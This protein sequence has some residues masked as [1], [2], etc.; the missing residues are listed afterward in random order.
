M[1]PMEELQ[2]LR[3]LAEL[4]AKAAGQQPRAEIPV[5][6]TLQGPAPVSPEDRY[7]DTPF[8]EKVGGGAFEAFNRSAEGLRTLLPGQEQDVG[9][10]A[11]TRG[12]QEF[13][14]G[15]GAP[16]YLGNVVGDIALASGPLKLAR[17]ASEGLGLTG[18]TARG[19]DLAANAGYSAAVEP[20]DRARAAAW[21]ATGALVGDLGA[22][23]LARVAKPTTPGPQAQ[24]L[25]DKKVPLTFGQV[26]NEK[27]GVGRAIGRTEEAMSGVP[28]AGAPL[29]A[30]RAE[31]MEGW[32]Q[33]TR[34][35]ALPPGR[36]RAG[37]AASVGN[38]IDAWDRAYTTTLRRV[39]MPRS[40]LAWDPPVVVAGAAQRAPVTRAQ[41]EAAEEF[42]Q[43]VMM[44]HVKTGSGGAT[45][46]ASIGHAIESE[47]KAKAG[48]YMK[49]MDPAQRE[50]G[51]LYQEVASD[52]ARAWRGALPD[53]RSRNA[54][55]R[56][57]RQYGN[58]IPVRE[59]A[60]KVGA[61]VS[62][63]DPSG[64]TPA[65]LLRAIRGKENTSTKRGYIQGNRPQQELA[66]AGQ[67]VVGNKVADSGTMER[68]LAGGGLLSAGGAAGAAG[69]GSVGVLPALAGMAVA[70][71]GLGLYGTRP[72][73]RYMTGQLGPLQTEIANYLRASSRGA[74][75][76]GRAIFTPED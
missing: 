1:T 56:L 17:K 37:D 48:S 27:G 67:R 11:R 62:D 36:H 45:V 41:A 5:D 21:G 73:Q 54:V 65:V 68:T 19:A 16:A 15:A 42:V 57:D 30:R 13:R 29:R 8:A 28:I 7:R 66:T 46:P 70:G 6:P 59:A 75:Q 72:V 74:A 18:A 44:K 52:W 39:Q 76:T 33:A 47:I 69:A 14:E 3:R 55:A 35:D 50:L 43:H 20:N 51:R 4:E 40:V 64:Y 61:A 10:R 9:S 32:Q 25:L 24:A 53:A 31:A 34:T 22:R 49:S 71:G 23:T 2:A 58:F 12:F 60:A 38:L 63:A 26:M